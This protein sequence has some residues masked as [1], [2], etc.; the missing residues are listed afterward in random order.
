MQLAFSNDRRSSLIYLAKWHV[1]IQNPLVYLA[2]GFGTNSNCSWC[3]SIHSR[4]YASSHI[5]CVRG[6]CQFES[7]WVPLKGLRNRPVGSWMASVPVPGFVERILRSLYMLVHAEH[8]GDNLS[9]RCTY[10]AWVLLDSWGWGQI[11][12]LT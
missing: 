6:P 9:T 2:I 7:L 12:G 8:K 4:S 11:R 3:P 1:Y 10:L 5:H